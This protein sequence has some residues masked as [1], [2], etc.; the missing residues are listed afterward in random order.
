LAQG[1]VL[2]L[3]A[4]NLVSFAFGAYQRFV[5]AG[6]SRA[7]AAGVSHWTTG[8]FGLADDAPP[9]A[10][11]L[12]TLPV[13]P[14]HPP[15]GD[16]RGRAQCHDPDVW[17]RF[18][19][20]MA[21]DLAA[22]M[23]PDA[24][25]DT[26]R[27]ARL[28]GFSWWLLG[29]W[30]IVRWAR[31]LS[32]PAAG[33]LALALWTIGPNVVAAEAAIDSALPAAVAALLATYAFRFYVHQPTGLKAMG[34]GLLLAMALLI[35]YLL[36]ALPVAWAVPWAV[37]RFGR[38]A[39]G[40]FLAKAATGIGR[41]ALMLVVCLW[42]INLGYGLQSGWQ[43]LGD[44]DFVSHALAGP[45]PTGPTA[46]GPNAFGNRFRDNPLGG[47]VIPVPLDY[48]RGL[49]RKLREIEVGAFPT[50][51]H[52]PNSVRRTTASIA[53]RVPLGTWA[54][55]LW[56]A[57]LAVMRR[58]GGA[59]IVD[60]LLLWAPV[61]LVLVLMEA[62]PSLVPLDRGL[63]L[64]APF[65]IVGVSRLARYVETGHWR[66][67]AAVLVLTACTV[68]SS[69]AGSRGGRPYLNEA[70][71][72]SG[73][74]QAQLAYGPGDGGPDLLELIAWADGHPEARPLRFAVR[75]GVGLKPFGLA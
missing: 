39:D 8:D 7:L 67:G 75:H 6:E 38:G 69:V 74:L 61:G 34:V 48:L 47:L 2:C 1:L 62:F 28:A 10:R 12:A 30:V 24:Y 36:I 9:L 66:P 4:I 53:A 72:G 65:A 35:D 11:M 52:R 23:V 63:V 20:R 26:A 5:T 58:R 15:V 45:R 64:T 37:S 43:P 25:L 18:E 13:L 40:A 41:A 22:A 19:D 73:N 31:E 71:G 51:E 46:W 55:L 42:A 59:P 16:V 56:T 50:G 32:G 17:S 68:I 27:L 29:A 14:L 44:Y 57:V 54:I 60:E 33:W 3:V 49:D 70:V 21:N